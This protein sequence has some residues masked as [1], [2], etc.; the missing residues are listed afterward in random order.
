MTEMS[1]VETTVI[2]ALAFE[3]PGLEVTE[4]LIGPVPV[5]ESTFMVMVKVV[6]LPLV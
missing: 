6:V 2:P 3:P 1:G 5:V 4:S